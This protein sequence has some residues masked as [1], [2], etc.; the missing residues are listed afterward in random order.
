MDLY[1][2][3]LNLKSI[4]LKLNIID[5]LPPPHPWEI[6]PRV[7]FLIGRTWGVTKNIVTKK[8]NKHEL[9]PLKNAGFPL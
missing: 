4:F 8:V 9:W 1:S 7:I 2:K 5:G 6:L 3:N